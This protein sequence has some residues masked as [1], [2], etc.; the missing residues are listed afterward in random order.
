MMSNKSFG[1]LCDDWTRNN[2]SYVTDWNYILAENTFDL[3]VLPSTIDADAKERVAA[4]AL[5]P[6]EGDVDLKV[7][8]VVLELLKTQVGLYER[9]GIKV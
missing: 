2:P 3:K 9:Y 6:N 8:A 7:A 1:I 4:R 5:I